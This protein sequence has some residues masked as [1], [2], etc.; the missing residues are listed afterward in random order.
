MTS[1]AGRRLARRAEATGFTPDKLAEMAA[2]SDLLASQDDVAAILRTVAA[3]A[4]D[5]ANAEYAAV[6]LVDSPGSP[7]R[8]A[9]AGTEEAL[10][11]RAASL[12]LVRGLLADVVTGNR[13]LRVDRL[14]P[15]A[16]STGLPGPD[17]ASAAL[18]GVPLRTGGA[19]IGS[20]CLVRGEGAAPF[21]GA[22]ELAVGVLALQAA[23]ALASSMARERVVLERSRADAI[24]EAI[25]DGVLEIAQDG[26]IRAVNRG[27]ERLLRYTP[28][29]V[30][31]RDAHSL[32]HIPRNGDANPR[33]ECRVCEVLETGISYRGD[34]VFR[35]SDGRHIDVALGSAAVVT[36]NGSRDGAVVIFNDVTERVRREQM[37]DDF[38]AFAA[39]ELR[40]PLATVMGFARWL[41]RRAAG[42]A[43]RFDAD[44][45][46]AIESLAIESQR[47]ASTLDVFLD[48]TRIQSERLLMEAEEVD[49]GAVV[50]EEVARLATSNPE[51]EVSVTASDKPLVGRLDPDRLRQILENL[52][53]NAV[54]Y[55]GSPPGVSIEVADSPTGAVVTVTDNGAGIS[56]ADRSHVFERF[57][58]SATS[59][60]AGKKG[61]G[62]GLY[63]AHEI[64]GRMG[65]TLTFVTD[66][67]G[68]TFT[69]SLPLSSDATEAPEDQ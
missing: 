30:L 7:G 23:A 26:T 10:E 40:S 28:A 33:D 52:L 50:R 41:Q 62:V 21:S 69:L 44:E 5:V 6:S 57:Y 45:H 2:T 67:G 20:L 68:T 1:A 54:K 13:S 65:G 19:T 36:P 56:E 53:T 22:D 61:L 59:S 8:L 43:D 18:L 9:Q 37:K 27:A 35:R 31:G 12:P 4:I 42:T 15:G 16:G 60:V 38:F 63:I 29:S 51:A 49:I 24:I 48:L 66:S 47:I 34:E 17:S 46:D 39:H 11:R 25:D 64:V 58:R 14:Q 55:G 3:R 32:L